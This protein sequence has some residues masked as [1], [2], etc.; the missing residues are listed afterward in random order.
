MNYL[1]G[2]VL[3]LALGVIM[4]VAFEVFE[5]RRSGVRMKQNDEQDQRTAAIVTLIWPVVLLVLIGWA[6]RQSVGSGLIRLGNKAIDL[7]LAVKSRLKRR[8]K[9]GDRT[10]GQVPGDSNQSSTS[11]SQGEVTP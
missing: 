5:P 6:L 11:E 2:I 1:W 3:Y 8:H 10:D 9:E 7:K 4:Y